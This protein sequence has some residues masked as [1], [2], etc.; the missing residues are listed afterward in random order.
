MERRLVT[1]RRVSALRPIAGADR[2]VSAAV[3]GWTCVVG[4]S[5]FAPG[6]LGVY[7]EIDSFLPAA[8]ARW[9]HLETQFRPF[10]GD[11]EARGFRVKSL[12]IRG[13]VSQGLLLPVTRFPEVEARLA[14]LERD[15]QGRE[16]AVEKAIAELAFEGALGVRKWDQPSAVGDGKAALVK[17]PSFI[18]RTDQE[19]VQNLKPPEWARYAD[20]VFQESTKM[21]GSSMTA[22]FLR[23][24]SPYYTGIPQASPTTTARGHFGVCS[25]NIELEPDSDGHFWAVADELDLHTKLATL[26]RSVA[27]QGELVGP[28]IQG[29]A[30]GFPL[31]KLAQK[32]GGGG[33]QPGR[34][35]MHNAQ[36]HF[37]VFGA[38]DI[39]AQAQLPPREVEVLATRLG[40]RHVPVA[41]YFALRD[42]GTGVEQFL[43]RAEGRGVNGRIR[44]GI[45][46]KA[47]DGQFSFKAISN[48][49]L[50][51]K[52]D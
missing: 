1:L 7:F 41:G 48:S 15:G 3:D 29:N 27:V 38:W 46:L 21:D 17:F 39:N 23:R 13:V 33:N 25:R 42:I 51:K 45:V 18:R 2:I 10:P 37:Y 52:G 34:A 32:H 16:A 9:G 19:R 30:E 43:A 12:K 14:E 36:H 4:I 26:G 47:E 6:D 24:D 50:L 20:V 11:A 49:Y 31:S 44:E 8:D 22:Y 40:L 28:S 35:S 5:E